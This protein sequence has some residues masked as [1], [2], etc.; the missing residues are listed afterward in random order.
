MIKTI[1]GSSP[2]TTIAGYIVAGLMIAQTMIESGVTN[3][4]R[5]ALAVG[6]AILGRVAG[7]EKTTK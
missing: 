2:Y 4:W 6:I 5:I 1:F 3:P 7:D